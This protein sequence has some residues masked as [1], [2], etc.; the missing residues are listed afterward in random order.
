V[1]DRV[2]LNSLL[3]GA[4][5]H[6]VRDDALHVIVGQVDPLVL[7]HALVLLVFEDVHIGSFRVFRVSGRGSRS[8]FQRLPDHPVNEFLL[9]VVEGV[10]DLRDLR[11]FGEGSGVN[12]FRVFDLF[13]CFGRLGFN[14]GRLFSVNDLETGEDDGL[15]VQ[16]LDVIRTVG[17]PDVVDQ[18]TWIG[19]GDHETDFT[20]RSV[21]DGLGLL[22]Q[23]VGVDGHRANVLVLH[24]LL[25]VE[26][27]VGVVEIAVAVNAVVTS[28]QQHVAENIGRLAVTVHPNHGHVLAIHVLERFGCDRAPVAALEPSLGHIT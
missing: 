23:L 1:L 5:L 14:L 19:P 28:F 27:L 13:L 25:G 10:E 2:G 8:H 12:E 15:V 11:V 26:T 17:D 21:D 3:E 18:S 22:D 4:A 7:G 20:D 9:L 24:Q 6:R 16:D